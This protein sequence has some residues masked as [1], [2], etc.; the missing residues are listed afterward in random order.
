MNKRKNTVHHSEHDRY[1]T[2]KQYVTLPI[3]QYN[4]IVQKMSKYTFFIKEKL[5]SK[6]VKLPKIISE[7]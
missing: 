2:I 6:I 4:M 5:D 1:L 3:I 7:D